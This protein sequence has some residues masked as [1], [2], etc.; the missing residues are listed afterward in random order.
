MNWEAYLKQLIHIHP[1]LESPTASNSVWIGPWRLD[2]N[3]MDLNAA[4]RFHEEVVERIGI[5]VRKALGKALGEA[6]HV[7]PH[8]DPPLTDNEI[9]EQRARSGVS[10]DTGM[11]P[12]G[13]KE[14]LA[15]ID[16]QKAR[17]AHMAK[18]NGYND[19]V[20]A[21]KAAWNKENYEWI[22]NIEYD[23]PNLWCP[24]CLH[25]KPDHDDDCNLGNY[26]RDNKPPT[27]KDAT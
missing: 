18:D 25:T 16:W 1:G 11:R 23:G 2:V 10:P 3:G 24:Q 7:L 20:E 6:L 9:E 26:L 4:K 12:R 5:V 15:M 27:V 19:G 8:E 14:L 22:A 13:V 17:I 21:G